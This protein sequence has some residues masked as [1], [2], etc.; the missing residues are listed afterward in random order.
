MEKSLFE[1]YSDIYEAIAREKQI[2]KWNR[3]KKEFLIKNEN[4][5]W[6]DLSKDWY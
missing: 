6:R 2:K 4:P 5:G 1:E 3:R